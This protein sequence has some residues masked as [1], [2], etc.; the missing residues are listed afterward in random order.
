MCICR[1]I[2]TDSSEN[3]CLMDKTRDELVSNTK[4]DNYRITEI[5]NILQYSPRT[6]SIEGESKKGSIDRCKYRTSIEQ[7]NKRMGI[8][9]NTYII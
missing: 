3:L 2:K 8:Y 4:S 6:N 1:I 9:R 7:F 5:K